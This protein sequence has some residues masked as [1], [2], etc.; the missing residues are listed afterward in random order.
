MRQQNF[1]LD[2]KPALIAEYAAEFL[3]TKNPLKRIWVA[4]FAIKFL[5]A[6]NLLE[7]F[8]YVS[9]TRKINTAMKLPVVLFQQ[10]KMLIAVF[11]YV[12]NPLV[13]SFSLIVTRLHLMSVQESRVNY[14]V[15][16]LRYI[17][18]AD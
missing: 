3:S 10:T 16:I 13:I 5:F 15:H 4:I 6:K 18:L 8:G 14:T 2:P 9:H 12:L 17:I 7:K 11:S 1:K